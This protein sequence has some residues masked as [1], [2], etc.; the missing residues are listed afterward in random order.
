MNKYHELETTL[1]ML[2]DEISEETQD[3]LS[4]LTRLRE[5][6]RDSAAYDEQWGRI[7]SALLV[8]KLKTDDA[9]KVM[10]K[11]ETFEAQEM[12]I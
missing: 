1:D 2:W 3:F 9:Y 10:E 7:A 6:Q 12:R 5:S 4:N 8:L 11:M